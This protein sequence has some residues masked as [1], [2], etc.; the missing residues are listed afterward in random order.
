MTRILLALGCVAATTAVAAQAATGERPH[1]AVASC[2]SRS[3]ASFPAAFTDHRNVVVGPLVLIGAASTPAATVR[4]F[5]GQK[6]PALVRAGHRVTV[7]LSPRTRRVAS[8][9]YG[10]LHATGPL[11]VRDGHRVV[12]FIACRRGVRSGSSADGRSVTFWSGF[13]LTATPRCVPLEFWVDDER[14]PRRVALPM[15]VRC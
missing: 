1:G 10:P 9:G 11:R 2:A 4:R 13:V 12:T 7:A 5:G 14:T 6:F 15:G 3:G 8:L